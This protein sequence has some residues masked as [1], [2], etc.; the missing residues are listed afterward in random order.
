VRLLGFRKDVPVLL[1]ASDLLI[2][3]TRYEAYGLGV[4]EALCNGLP[5]LVSRSAG[6]AERYPEELR[7]LLL[8]DP[9]D[10]ED[11]VRR[12]VAWR[13]AD[14]ELRRRVGG[15]SATLR[16][17]TWDDMARRIHEL[18]EQFG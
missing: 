14:E 7:E 18:A 12:V 9:D 6:V 8:P 15:L 13:S 10:V 16:A 1:R 3:P 2:A 11:L 5:A 4:H 17:W